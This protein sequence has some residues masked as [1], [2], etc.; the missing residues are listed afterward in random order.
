MVNQKIYFHFVMFYIDKKNTSYFHIFLTQSAGALSL[1]P[2]LDVTMPTCHQRIAEDHG[3]VVLLA[4]ES[5]QHL[6][7][8]QS[9][10]VHPIWWGLLICNKYD[11]EYSKQVS[12][13]K[14]HIL[15]KNMNQS[16]WVFLFSASVLAGCLKLVLRYNYNKTPLLRRPFVTSKSGLNSEFGWCET[17]K[18][19]NLRWACFNLVWFQLNPSRPSALFSYAQ[20]ECCLLSQYPSKPQFGL[21]DEKN[22]KHK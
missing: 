1:L 8:K 17:F 16:H 18:S 9:R 14:S 21:N 7:K 11:T 12:S 4:S 5:P 19:E 10:D 6:D 13:N 15:N 3:N 2:R 20:W 22:C